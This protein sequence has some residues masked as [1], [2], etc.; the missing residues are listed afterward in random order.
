[1]SF[2]PAMLADGDFAIAEGVG[3]PLGDYAA[4]P[5]VIPNVR[6]IGAT[7]IHMGQLMR[8][9]AEQVGFDSVRVEIDSALFVAHRA[10]AKLFVRWPLDAHRPPFAVELKAE[11]GPL[12]AGALLHF[13]R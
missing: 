5:F 7:E 1:M 12:F 10:F 8:D 6:L 4:K 13:S 11:G 3:Q 9:D 2:V